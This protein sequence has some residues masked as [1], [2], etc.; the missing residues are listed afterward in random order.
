MKSTRKQ[1][2]MRRQRSPAANVSVGQ[3]TFTVVITPNDP[4][5][6]LVTCPALPGLVTEGN[7]FDEA[8]QMA[9]DAIACHVESMIE[10]GLPIPVDKTIITPVSVKVA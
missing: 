4:D 7:T 10:D 1:T 5:G 9:A 3:Y 6:Y 2:P 8:R